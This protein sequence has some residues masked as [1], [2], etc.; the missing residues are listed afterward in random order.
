MIGLS[1][2]TVSRYCLSRRS[3]MRAPRKLIEPASAVGTRHR[4]AYRFV[5]ACPSGLAIVVSH[6]GA[7]RFVA[8]L[9]GQVVY[10]EQFLNW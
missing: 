5:M 4:A 8:N 9:D 2:S 3:S 6:D 1:G 7:V 10:W